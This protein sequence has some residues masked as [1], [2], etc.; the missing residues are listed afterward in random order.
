MENCKLT[1]PKGQFLGIDDLATPEIQL[2]AAA[3]EMLVGCDD[4]VWL[5]AAPTSCTIVCALGESADRQICCTHERDACLML[6]AKR[7]I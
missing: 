5:V 6:T 7:L 4:L 3:Q 1:F 2:L